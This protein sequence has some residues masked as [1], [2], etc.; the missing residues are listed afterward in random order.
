MPFTHYYY[1]Q[2]FFYFL[3]CNNVH[4]FVA[5]TFFLVNC[6]LKLLLFLFLLIAKKETLLQL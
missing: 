5:V 1:I 6:Y 3:A 4:R 2:I